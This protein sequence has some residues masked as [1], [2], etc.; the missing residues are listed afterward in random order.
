MTDISSSIPWPPI[1]YNSESPELIEY[2][3]ELHRQLTNYLE[4]NRYISGDLEV[5]GSVQ[6][7]EDATIEGMLIATLP[8]GTFSSLVTQP[9]LDVAAA[10]AIALD[11][12]NDVTRLTHS[13]TTLNSKIT[14]QEKG[15]YELIISGV[16][17]IESVDR[18]KYLELWLSKN[19]TDVPNTNTRVNI[20]EPQ[21]EG[22]LAIAFIFDLEVGDYIELMTWGDSLKCQWLYTAAG[23]TPTRPAVPSIIVSM[24]RISGYPT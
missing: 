6:V 2:I 10:Q 3:V 13:T 5:G 22:V 14:A 23:T 7:Q 16:Y 11:D 24:K 8:H 20:Q 15:S 9:I 4:G 17:S 21:E 18:D 19:G 12:S 1:P